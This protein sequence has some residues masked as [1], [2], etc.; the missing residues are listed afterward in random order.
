MLLYRRGAHVAVADKDPDTLETLVTTLAEAPNLK[1]QKFSATLVDVS[2]A[3][4][5]AL[6]RPCRNRR[7]LLLLGEQEE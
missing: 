5:V 7:Q 2:S 4:A 1:D 6:T 3:N